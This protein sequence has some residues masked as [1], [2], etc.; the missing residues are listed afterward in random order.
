MNAGRCRRF[1]AGC[2]KMSPKHYPQT[3]CL[4]M[5]RLVRHWQA[6]QGDHLDLFLD[7]GEN[8]PLLTFGARLPQLRSFLAG[9]PTRWEWKPVHRRAY[10]HRGGE[11]SGGR[12]RVIPLW[13][14]WHAL[15]WWKWEPDVAKSKKF[16]PV[17]QSQF[18]APT[19]VLDMTRNTLQITR[20]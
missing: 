17:Q 5:A 9:L 10:L 14:G 3:Q 19:I 12:G 18:P 11:V 20:S 6:P 15:P 4:L 1:F 2:R 7:I 13:E 16:T 8:R